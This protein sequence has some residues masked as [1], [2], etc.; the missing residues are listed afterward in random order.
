MAKL[1]LIRGLP[2]SGKSTLAKRYSAH[3]FEADMYF[4]N[5]AGEHCFDASQLE[6][7]HRW[8]QQQTEN[9]L[10]KGED[11]VVSNTFVR[12]WEIKP[13]FEMAKKLAAQFE[14]VECKGNYGS[15]HNV[16]QSVIDKMRTRWQEWK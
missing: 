12:R 16:D 9:A 1:T 4:V 6:S 15:V 14:I 10:R 11:V 13:Y 3:H 8:C 7:A 5:A 2:G